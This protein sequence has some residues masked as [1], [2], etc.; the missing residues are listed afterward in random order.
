MWWRKIRTRADDRGWRTE[1]SL[2]GIAEG[3]DGRAED[4][5]RMTEGGDPTSL[6]KLGA[7][8]SASTP[9]VVRAGGEMG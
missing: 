8:L 3:D 7:T 4:R 5:I 1:D 9:H 6:C 2:P